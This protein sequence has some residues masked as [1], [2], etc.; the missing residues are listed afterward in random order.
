MLEKEN[1]SPPQQQNEEVSQKE[2]VFEASFS[3]RKPK[4]SPKRK[5]FSVLNGIIIHNSVLLFMLGKIEYILK[6]TSMIFVTGHPLNPLNDP[7]E[8]NI[9]RQQQALC[10]ANKGKPSE[11]KETYPRP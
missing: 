6:L 3:K 8:K 1:V 9:G 2:D 4:A 7:S 11:L 10:A 5:P